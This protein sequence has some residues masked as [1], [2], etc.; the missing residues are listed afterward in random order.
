MLATGT[1]LCR[2]DRDQRQ[3]QIT[4]FFEQAM[5][6]S[7]INHRTGYECVAIFLKRDGQALKP[8]PP[9]MSQVTP[10]PDLIDHSLI[11]RWFLFEFV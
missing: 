2:I 6:G 5:Q 11:G 1:P 9:F 7:L 8:V 3:T 10:D 4:H